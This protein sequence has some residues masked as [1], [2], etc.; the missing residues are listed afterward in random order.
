MEAS[1]GELG[2]RRASWDGRPVGAGSNT[3]SSMLSEGRLVDE[4]NQALGDTDPKTGFPRGLSRAAVREAIEGRPGKALAEGV[5]LAETRL[6]DL[7]NRI[8][9]VKQRAAME[10][11]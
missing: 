9:A 4:L 6:T 1:P 8:E 11:C 7:N 5:Q 2:W 3:M 10:G